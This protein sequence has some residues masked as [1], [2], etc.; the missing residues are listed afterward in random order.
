M[1]AISSVEVIDS[2]LSF[3]SA[4]CRLITLPT[5]VTATINSVE[6]KYLIDARSSLI[7]RNECARRKI[8]LLCGDMCAAASDI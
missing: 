5:G 4:N 1:H 7:F 3:S 8:P 6:A 2:E